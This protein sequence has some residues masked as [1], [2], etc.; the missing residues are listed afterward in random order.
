[1]ASWEDWTP[2]GKQT[3]MV[4]YIWQISWVYSLLIATIKSDRRYSTQ[5]ISLTQTHNVGSKQDELKLYRSACM[6]LC[7]RKSG[8]L[9][10]HMTLLWKITIPAMG[11]HGGSV[12]RLPT[13]V[14]RAITYNRLSKYEQSVIPGLYRKLCIIHLVKHST[15]LTQDHQP[16]GATG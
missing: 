6:Y 9:L 11:Y 3:K 16:L 4:Y 15:P 5:V 13:F 10:H 7:T 12:I 8:N 2:L 1:M 14:S